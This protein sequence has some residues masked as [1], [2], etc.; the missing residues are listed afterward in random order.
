AVGRALAARA[1]T[2][3]L[4]TDIAIARDLPP[5]VVGDEMRLRAA[6]ENLADNAVKFTER[7]GVALAV[8]AQAAP[9]GRVRLAFA[10]S[11]SGIG[12]SK[13]DIARLFRPFAQASE[14]IARRY[15]GAGLGLVFVRRI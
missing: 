3:G 15:G 1:E 2:R 6:L 14:D 10:L 11:D 9:R 12:L 7:G 8:S 4:K 5:L 13:Q